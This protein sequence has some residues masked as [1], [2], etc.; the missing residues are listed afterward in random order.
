MPPLP[1]RPFAVPVD[2]GFDP[3]TDYYNSGS[4]DQTTLRA[5]SLAF[6]KYR[7][8]PRVLRPVS[9]VSTSTVCFGRE[10][11]FPLCVSP[12]GI[13]AIAHPEGELA[14]S[15]ACA[16]RGVNMA[17]S[18]FANYAVE[19]VRAAGVA[20]DPRVRHAMQSYT[21]RDRV[22]QR[23]ML[24]RAHRAGCTAVLLTADSPVLGVRYNEWR[25]DFRT[26]A[27]L[28]FP[29]VEMGSEYVRTMSHEEGFTTMGDPDHEWGREVA[30]LRDA[31][32]QME[33][34]VKGVL[35]AEDVREAV[36][37]GVDGVLVS[38][39][40]GRQLDG[41]PATIDVLAECVEAAKGSAVRIHVDGGIRSGTDIF[42]CLA[43]GAECCWVGR[44]ALWGLAVRIPSL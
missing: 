3:P 22:L 4:T 38:N 35:T 39:H 10:I 16:A 37:W 8:R 21:M 33:I 20:V 1:H 14:T 41:V 29:N 12:A 19:E 15:R 17:I 6:Q 25:H 28:G 7:L 18:T 23:R 42:K 32:P 36:R 24:E 30:W 40:G 9:A 43:L 5:N 31:A 44:P 27:G 2:H 26:P 13:Q 11:A 34:W